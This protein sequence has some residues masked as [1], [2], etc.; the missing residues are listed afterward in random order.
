MLSQAV[1]ATKSL[2]LGYISLLEIK[3]PYKAATH[4]HWAVLASTIG[5]MILRVAIAFSTGLLQ[6]SPT[7]LAKTVPP[8]S[9]Q[10]AFDFALREEYPY[11]KSTFIVTSLDP[12]FVYADILKRSLQLLN[13]TLPGHVFQSIAAPMASGNLTSLKAQVTA[14]VS[15][16][17]C[18]TSFTAPQQSLVEDWELAPPLATINSPSC[19]AEGFPVTGWTTNEVHT[20]VHPHYILART[21][22]P[23][24]CSQN[25]TLARN[26]TAKKLRPLNNRNLQDIADTRLAFIFHNFTI[27]DNPPLTYIDDTLEHTIPYGS[28]LTKISAAVCKVNYELRPVYLTQYPINETVSLSASSTGGPTTKFSNLT[29]S[30]LSEVLFAVL[31]LHDD[32]PLALDVFELMKNEVPDFPP[33]SEFAPFMDP[34]TL[35]SSA[36]AVLEGLLVQMVQQFILAPT[37]INSSGITGTA[38]ITEDRLHIQPASLWIMVAAFIISSVLTLV[39]L[40]SQPSGTVSQDPTSVATLAAILTAS[41]RSQSLLRNTA[42]LG[43]SELRDWLDGYLFKASVSAQGTFSIE[44]VGNAPLY[45]RTDA[46][47]YPFVILTLAL[48]VLVISFLELLYQLSKRNQGL[49]ATDKGLRNYAVYSTSAITAIIAA[50]LSSVKFAFASFAPFSVLCSRENTHPGSTRLNLIGKT[51]PSMLHYALRHRQIGA[52]LSGAAGIIGSVLT[53]IASGPWVDRPPLS[54]SPVNTS[55][56]AAWNFERPT[57]PDVSGSAASTFARVF[58]QGGEQPLGMWNDLVFPK[59]ISLDVSTASIRAKCSEAGAEAFCQFN[60]T[61][62]APRPRLACEQVPSQQ[63]QPHTGDE[64]SVLNLPFSIDLPENCDQN[65]PIYYI[66]PNTDRPDW[67]GYF[68]EVATGSRILSHNNASALAFR[69]VPFSSNNP[70]GCPSISVDFGGPLGN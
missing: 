23:V 70:T 51:P 46:A 11:Y 64:V 9:E 58:L 44:P 35:K 15:N 19:I 17:T 5:Y 45:K 68:A 21:L 57:N 53:V 18:D 38:F 39:I 52:A 60:L 32:L 40:C 37:T 10:T 69:G 50:T 42:T 59:M 6:S 43:T 22:T 14:F 48:P 47:L 49:A 8:Y 2:L 28:T 27:L 16:I 1:D 30:D 55:L 56:A 31:G 20:D 62:P 29:E 66:R 34:V 63:I 54:V 7:L 36:T 61:V 12:L 4:R 41:T 65:L 67:V 24:N 3:T 25:E 33:G 26:S 13:G